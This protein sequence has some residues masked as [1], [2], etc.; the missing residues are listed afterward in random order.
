MSKDDLILR[1]RKPT[2]EEMAALLRP[3]SKECDLV[4]IAASYGWNKE[5]YVT[6]TIKHL[7]DLENQ[8]QWKRDVCVRLL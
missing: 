2:L 3:L 1:L 4:A 5:E 7:R 6:E 8:I